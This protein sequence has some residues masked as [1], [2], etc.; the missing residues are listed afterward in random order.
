VAEGAEFVSPHPDLI[1][2][3]K[4][5]DKKSLPL[6]LLI[7]DR[8]N[9]GRAGLCYSISRTPFLGHGK[10]AII[11]DADFLETEG[12]NALLKTLEEPPEDSLLIL[13]GTSTTNQLPTIR[14]RCKIIRFSPL[15]TKTLARLLVEQEVV[16]TQEQGLQLAKRS[17]G[18]L[19]HARELVDDALDEL[20]GELNKQLSA[21]TPDTV[22]FAKRLNEFVA[23]T[24][25]G[26]P[27]RRRLR[28]IF[29]LAMEQF[30]DKFRKGDETAGR[31]LERTLDALEQ[32]DRNIN[33]PLIIDAWCA[34]ITV[35]WGL[36]R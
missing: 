30:R 16:A 32:V 12:A 20:R 24:D 3:A 26:A 9:R 33:L 27:Q 15:S 6:E 22:G 17:D 2:V 19:D 31:H 18:G 21:T 25:K 28:L 34:E 29:T 11:D 7:G 36:A 1:Y 23:A 8:E 35:G 14:S 4:P 5:M 13:I 10:V